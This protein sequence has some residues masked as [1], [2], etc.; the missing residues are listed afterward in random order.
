MVQVTIG[1]KTL[2]GS[3]AAGQTRGAHLLAAC[4]PSE[5]IALAQVEVDGK[6]NEVKAARGCC[7]LPVC[8]TRLVSGGA[9]LTQQDLSEQ[10]AA[11]G[12]EYLWPV[13]ENQPQ[14]YDDIAAFFA[15]EEESTA[16]RTVAKVMGALSNA[17][18]GPAP[19]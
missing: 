2:Q 16:A 9:M 11:A 19:A 17:A 15:S 8:G 3:I 5:G 18:C 1:G 10:V 13:K 12:G 7:R 6:E 14:L 4:L